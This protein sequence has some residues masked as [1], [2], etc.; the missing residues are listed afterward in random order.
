MFL[1]RK[2]QGRR[3][4]EQ[5]QESRMFLNLAAPA[6]PVTRKEVEE[7]EDRTILTAA[8]ISLLASFI[9]LT[10]TAGAVCR[11]RSRSR[12][13]KEAENHVYQLSSSSS[14]TSSYLSSTDYSYML[15]SDGRTYRTL[16]P[17]PPHSLP[18]LPLPPQ[19]LASL[20]PVPVLPPYP[21][22]LEE[23]YT[24]RGEELY[25]GRVEELY[26][27]PDSQQG[28]LSSSRHSLSGSQG[29]HWN[30]TGQQGC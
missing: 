27:D 20:Q 21:G 22:R 6:L 7:E 11:S 17:S 1:R 12:G 3:Q 30:F 5:E 15:G 28:A 16:S 19:S 14:S 24:G 2:E 25:R 26:C 18:S 9:L 8:L 13:Q 10:I 29:Q 4:Q 23:L